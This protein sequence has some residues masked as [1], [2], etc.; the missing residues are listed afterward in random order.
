M[1]MQDTARDT[2]GTPATKEG[3]IKKL[4]PIALIACGAAAGFFFLRDFLSFETLEQNYETLI[5]W[6]EENFVAMI[7]AYFF[8]YVLVVAFSIPGAIWMTLLGGFLFG[9]VTGSAIVILAA[10]T[11]ATLLFLAAK[12]S[13]GEVLRSKAGGWI[14]KLEDEFRQGEI[15]FLL[16]MRLVPVMP[17]FVANLVPAFLGTRLFNFVWTTLVGI[18][19]GTLVFISIGSG[20]GAQLG[21]GEPPNLNVIFEL[22]VLGPLLGLAMLASL[23]IVLRKLGIT[24]KG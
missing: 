19:P 14:T 24:S 18:I 11:G 22:H 2:V 10:T 7:A 1:T 23:P 16:I 6:R 9:T 12:T 3:G 5:A 4:L 17:F 13:L 15:S 20:L 21:T 8:I